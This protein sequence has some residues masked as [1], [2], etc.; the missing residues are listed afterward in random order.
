MES[1]G[2]RLY[3]SIYYFST[4]ELVL[5]KVVMVMAEEGDKVARGNLSVGPLKL[6]PNRVTRPF[7]G[8][9]LLDRW[10]QKDNPQDGFAPEDWVA[11]TVQAQNENTDLLEGLSEVDGPNLER[12]LLRNLIDSHPVELLGASH[13][14]KYGKNM[15]LLVKIL[16]SYTRL[17]LQVHP[18]RDYAK[19]VFGSEFGKTEAWYILGG[20]KVNGQDPYVL[21]GFKPGMTREKWS[22]LFLR[23]DIQ[24]MCDSLHRFPVQTGD[25]FLVE[26]GVP[27]AI[28][29][30]CFLLEIQEPTDFTMRVERKS[31]EGRI[32]SDYQ[33]HQGAGFARMLECFHYDSYTREKVLAK[34]YRKPHIIERNA[35]GIQR[36]LV[37]AEDT[38]LFSMD[39]VEVNNAYTCSSNSG[40]SVVVVA[41]GSGTL[42]WAQGTLELGQGDELF[43]PASLGEVVWESHA[44]E[45][46]KLIRCFPPK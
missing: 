46:L 29:S 37:S 28:G 18:D 19:A 9:M 6:K 1:S 11:S 30:G 34:Y 36:S 21:L 10:Q 45:D 23:Q 14:R 38:P 40:F 44:A 31:P 25:V 39:E 24:G 3:G 42:T 7:K 15:A 17:L 5:R 35:G 8:G 16:D 33:C 13:V 4:S 26:S 43:L 32:L 12:E 27:H 2:K 22:E 20:R 41:S